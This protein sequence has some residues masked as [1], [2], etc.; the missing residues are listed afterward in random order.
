[1]AT[2]AKVCGVTTPVVATHAAAAGADF[3]GVVLVPGTPRFVPPDRVDAIVHAVHEAGARTVAVT[4]DMPEADLLAL[5][6]DVLQLHGA[7]PPALVARVTAAGR[8]VW[9]ALRVGPDFDPG[10]AASFTDA[11]A[12]AV[13]LDAWHPTL[14]GG[15]GLRTDPDVAAAIA[16]DRR[17][18][19]AGG[20]GPDNV[21]AAIAAVRPWAVDA[22]SGLESAPGVKDPNLVAAWVAAVRRSP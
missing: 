8:R 2:F 9:K 18:V 22:S 14:A 12:E 11:G 16:R 10:L 6:F 5:P 13:L 17:V 7:E 21:A 15:T 4:A 20:L 19:L 3:V 1:M